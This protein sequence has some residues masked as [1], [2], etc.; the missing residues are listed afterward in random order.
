MP[1]AWQ[2]AQRRRLPAANDD[3]PGHDDLPAYADFI[4]GTMIDS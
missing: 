4:A 2:V 3:A 1:R